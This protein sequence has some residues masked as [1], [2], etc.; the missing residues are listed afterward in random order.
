[1]DCDILKEFTTHRRN[2]IFFSPK[3]LDILEEDLI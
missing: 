3:I 1:M 2:K